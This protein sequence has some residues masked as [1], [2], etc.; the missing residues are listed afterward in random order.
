MARSARGRDAARPA[1]GQRLTPPGPLRYEVQY[2]QHARLVREE[3]PAQL[4]WIPAGS[5]GQFVDEALQDK[6]VLRRA[7]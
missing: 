3:F 1:R 7:D 4:D 2:A 6:D 5:G